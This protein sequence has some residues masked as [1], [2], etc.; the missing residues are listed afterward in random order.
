MADYFAVTMNNATFDV[1]LTMGTSFPSSSSIYP[2][3][4]GSNPLCPLSHFHLL[5]S[6]LSAVEL[7]RA[8]LAP[9]LP[10]E[11]LNF[12][13]SW[14]DFFGFRRVCSYDSRML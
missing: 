11:D 7:E 13:C 1:N 6:L 10:A 3:W 5:A 14:T 9:G 12:F 4:G 8:L 2:T